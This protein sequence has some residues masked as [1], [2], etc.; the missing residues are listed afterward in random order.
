MCISR[1]LD[2]T[3]SNSATPFFGGP[4]N[5]LGQGRVL[6]N[7]SLF[8]A[9]HIKRKPFYTTLSF[10]QFVDVEKFLAVALC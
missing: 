7:S 4:Q 9:V 10:W 1:H 3:I 8:Q 5:C 6:A 2:N